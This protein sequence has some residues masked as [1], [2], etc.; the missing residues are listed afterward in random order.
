MG[1][2]LLSFLLVLGTVPCFLVILA[3]SGM[4]PPTPVLKNISG[5]SPRFRMKL[6]F[7]RGFHLFLLGTQA[8]NPCGVTLN[9]TGV[10]WTASRSGTPSPQGSLPAD[11]FPF[12]FLASLPWLYS[13]AMLSTLPIL[14]VYFWF[15]PCP[16]P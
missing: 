14:W 4:L 2:I 11:G 10:P 1:Q 9:Y 5:E 3:I 6:L 16:A 15:T 12:A 7:Q 8:H 13:Q